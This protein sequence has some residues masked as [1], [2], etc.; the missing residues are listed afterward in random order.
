ML[1]ATRRT[2][3]GFPPVL[4]DG[5]VALGLMACA[6]FVALQDGTLSPIHAAVLALVFLPL[7]VRRRWP[8]PVTLVVG[9]ALLINL[10][11]GYR[12][13]FFETFA[14]LLAAY[15]MYARSSWRWP[16]LW[17]SAILFLGLNGSFL[18]DWHN[19]GAVNWTDLPYNYLVFGVS[20]AF[21]YASRA[22]R[23]YA[24]QLEER[25]RLL[26]H[27][28][29][30]EERNRIARELH[31]VVAHG[32]SV[33]VLQAT[34]GSRVAARD[35]TRAAAALEVIQETGREALESLR[36]AV[37]VLRANSPVAPELEP[38][39]DLGQLEL[40]IEQVRRA[41]LLVELQ[42]KGERRPLPAGVELSAYRVVQ[43]SLTNVL[44]HAR[45]SRVRVLVEYADDSLSLEVVDDGGGAE[46]GSIA[47]SAPGHGLAG[48][49]ERVGLFGGELL[50]DLAEGGF[51]VRAHIPLQPAYQ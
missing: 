50:A 13:S 29:A 36:R 39:P 17:T 5:L 26:A 12:D 2:L 1:N 38:L 25:N 45:A 6:D 35:P 22:H 3:A 43:E 24:A 44:K 21:G 20:V 47:E 41:G 49:R 15:T 18:I 8:T 14:I 7:T 31:D 27:E 16:L 48:M 46:G 4:I 42:V 28:V 32:V 30:L 19:K 9:A 37:G 23:A 10:G 40:L 34:A 11:A 33:M 51:R